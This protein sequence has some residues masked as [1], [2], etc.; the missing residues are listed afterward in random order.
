MK[1]LV[2]FSLKS[3]TG[4]FIVTLLISMFMLILQF[5][6]VY[7]DDLMGKGLSVWVILELLVYVS[8]GIVPL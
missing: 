4:P 6:W 7:I 1:R 5:F 3:F 8:A 2:L